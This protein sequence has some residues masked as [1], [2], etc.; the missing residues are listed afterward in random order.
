MVGIIYLFWLFESVLALFGKRNRLF[1]MII[2]QSVKYSGNDNPTKALTDILMASLLNRQKLK[3]KERTKIRLD[4]L[5][6]IQA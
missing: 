6:F 5:P 1:V 4:G 3:R 2:L